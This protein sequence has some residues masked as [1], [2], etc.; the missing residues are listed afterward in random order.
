[1]KYLVGLMLLMLAQVA[2]AVNCTVNHGLW[3]DPKN[4]TFTTTAAVY[5]STDPAD[6]AKIILD[7]LYIACLGVPA[8][9]RVEIWTVFDPIR[10]APQFAHYKSGIKLGSNYY[11]SP[12]YNIRTG[13]QQPGDGVVDDPARVF[14]VVGSPPNGY[15]QIPAGTKI[16]TYH[17]WVEIWSGTSRIAATEMKVNVNSRNALNLNPSTCTINNNNPIVVDF[18]S[19]DPLVAGGEGSSTT[20]YKKTVPLNYSCPTTGINS[21]MNVRL[22]GTASSFNSNALKINKNDNLAA[23]MTR[24]GVVVAPGSSF[25]ANISNSS[26]SDTVVFGLIRNAGNLPAAGPFDAS[27]TLVMSPP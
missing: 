26:G 9:G 10:L 13:R 27:A 6:G 24:N 22:V 2:S 25:T 15:I 7:E 23:T 11:S 8:P 1:M 17:V 14:L 3:R 4:Y 18:G 19:V 12:V 16:L 5:R 21:S 20:P